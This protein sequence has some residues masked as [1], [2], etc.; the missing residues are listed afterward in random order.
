V[1]SPGPDFAKQNPT[2]PRLDKITVVVDMHISS[3]NDLMKL[4]PE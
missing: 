4:Q 1:T 2:V 3:T